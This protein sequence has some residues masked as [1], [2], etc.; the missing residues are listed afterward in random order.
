MYHRNDVVDALRRVDALGEHVRTPVPLQA[1]ADVDSARNPM[2]LTRERLERAAT[3]NQFMNGK[4]AAIDV[5]LSVVG[6]P[7]GK[8][9]GGSRIAGRWTRRSC[10]ASR[11]SGRI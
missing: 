10:R 9:T 5:R 11:S 1:L 7:S 4:I 6:R 8:L 2:Q 3:E